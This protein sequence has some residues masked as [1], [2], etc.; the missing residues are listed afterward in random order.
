MEKERAME[1]ITNNP[2]STVN[3]EFKA[4]KIINTSIVPLLFHCN[5]SATRLLVF[6]AFN[7]WEKFDLVLYVT[8]TWVQILLKDKI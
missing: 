7:L 1:I 3:I 4:D 6:I 8:E 2:L 5:K